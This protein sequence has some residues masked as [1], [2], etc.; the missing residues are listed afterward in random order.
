[1]CMTSRAS[2]ANELVQWRA[3]AL[4]CPRTTAALDY[5]F[6]GC[7]VC[8]SLVFAENCGLLVTFS[9]NFEIG[10]CANSS[11][12][13]STSASSICG[14]R[15]RGKSCFGSSFGAAVATASGG[16]AIGVTT[17]SFGRDF[18]IGRCDFVVDNFAL[19]CLSVAF[20]MTT[21]FFSFGFFASFDA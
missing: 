5:G 6:C 13:Y 14:V 1:R 8:G 19:L 18:G 9:G 17:Q 20:V 4:A 21:A 16:V 2:S 15:A 3:C 12:R 10:T 7:D 11:S